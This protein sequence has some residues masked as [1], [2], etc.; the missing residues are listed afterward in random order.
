MGFVKDTSRHIEEIAEALADHFVSGSAD[1][2]QKG[3]VHTL[4]AA[5]RLQRDITARRIFEH[6]LEIIDPGV[7]HGKA[8]TNVRIAAITSSGA[9][10][11]GQ[12]PVASRIIISL[13][14]MPRW[15][16]SPTSFDAMMSSLH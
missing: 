15:T 1:P 11:L 10:R 8:Q 16:N 13:F 3:F 6:V 7:V 14:G 4:D 9:L 12:W 5:V 2:S